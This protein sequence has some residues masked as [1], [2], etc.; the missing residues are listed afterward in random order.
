[1]YLQSHVDIDYCIVLIIGWFFHLGLHY[2][3]SD[4]DIMYFG[5]RVTPLTSH[6]RGHMLQMI[7]PHLVDHA[8]MAFPNPM[9][10]PWTP[11]DQYKI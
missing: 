11:F 10:T 7:L 3:T 2:S 9:Q 1:M 5:Y 4:I 6:I 8:F